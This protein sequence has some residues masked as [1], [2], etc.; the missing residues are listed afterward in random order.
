MRGGRKGEVRS[1]ICEGAERLCPAITGGMDFPSPLSC[2]AA[3]NNFIN[4]SFI[5]ILQF[6]FVFY[7][8]DGGLDS[9]QREV[10][11]GYIHSPL[12]FN[13]YT[14]KQFWGSP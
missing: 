14:K 13:L 5:I 3:D 9:L 11:Q 12:L 4:S 8:L 2:P 6:Q 10:R 7:I 1:A